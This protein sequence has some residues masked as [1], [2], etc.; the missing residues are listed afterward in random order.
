MASAVSSRVPT[1]APAELSTLRDAVVL[2]LRSPAEF[3]QD[4]LPGAHNVPLFDD[5]ERAIVGTLYSK[6]SPDAAWA[7]GRRIAQRR[8]GELV[9]RVANLVG[10]GA[11]DT[12]LSARAAEWTDGGIEALDR[13][14]IA[15]ACE[16]PP[17]RAVVLHC[18]R[19]G[20]RSRSVTSFLRSL[21]LERAVALDGGYKAYREWVRAGLDA[22]RAPPAFVLRGLTGVGKTLVLREIERLR[23][24]ST[25]DLEDLAGHRGSILGRVGLEPRPQKWFETCL[26]QRL[27]EGFPDRCV[28]EGESRKVGD[29]ILPRPVW[30]AVDGG[31]ALELVATP[32]QRANVL[33]ADYL[34][35]PES[36]AQIA[37]QLPFLERRLGPVKYAGEL[38]RLLEGGRE[39]ELVLL[40]LELYYDPLYRSSERGR[41]YRARFDASN[42]RAAAAAILDWLDREA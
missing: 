19:G 2:D 35:K 1:V 7:E 38:T 11:P 39:R 36:R 15:E 9:E 31:V 4:H 42:P 8:I 22:W 37:A 32:D 14:L 6:T 20:L 10:W 24:G 18:W 3:A 29:A 16:T 40:L 23:P 41:T 26:W 17:E 34:M 21:G 25:L 28:V 12:D 13:A 30:E 27:R 33:L 5:T